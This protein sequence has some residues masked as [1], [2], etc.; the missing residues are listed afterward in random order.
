[1]ANFSNEYTESCESI[2]PCIFFFFFLF[3]KNFV[4][5]T[6]FYNKYPKRFVNVSRVATVKGSKYEQQ[7]V[8]GYTKR[9]ARS[10]TDLSATSRVETIK[11]SANQKRAKRFS[12]LH[13]KFRRPRARFQSHLFASPCILANVFVQRAATR[14]TFVIFSHRNSLEQA[15]RFDCHFL[16]AS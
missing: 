6:Y 7:K 9:H 16:P 2:I 3:T 10:P 14:L 8:K 12:K 5:L 15:V 4:N 13:E 1:M 11:Y